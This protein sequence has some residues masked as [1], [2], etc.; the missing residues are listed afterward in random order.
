MNNSILNV[1]YNEGERLIPFV[2]HNEDEVIR[3]FSSYNFFA[4]IIHQDIQEKGINEVNILDIGFGCGYGCFILSKIQGVKQVTGIDVSYACKSYAQEKYG[5]RN[6]EFVIADAGEYLKQNHS[7]NYITSRGV[8][9]HIPNGLS[10]TNKSNYHQRLIIDVPYNEKPGN[11]HH[12]LLGIK[13]DAFQE[14]E[15]YELFYE[16]LDGTIYDAHNKPDDANMILCVASRQGLPP[17]SKMFDFPIKPVTIESVK[18]E[19]L[20]RSEDSISQ[21][22]NRYFIYQQ[23]SDLLLAV[24]KVIH[25]VDVV[26]DIGP[27]IAPMNYFRPKFHILL[28]PF[29]EY[30]QILTHRF[31]NDGSVFI[32]SDTAQDFMS[33]LATNSV[34]SVFLLDLIEHLPK[35]D[36]VNLLA[37]AE[38][39]ARKQIIIFTPLGFMPQT[40]HEDEKDAWGLGG[41]SV[42]EHLSGWIP[43]DFGS[44]WDFYICES[45]HK[46]DF[47]NQRLDKEYGTFF[48][49][50]NF[51]GKPTPTPESIPNIRPLLPSE[52]EF[53]KVSIELNQTK[54]AL[55]NTQNQLVDIQ[56]QLVNTQNQLQQLE[57]IV[58]HPIVRALRKV[59]KLLI[60][61]KK[62]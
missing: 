13:E 53:K 50:K 7:F 52:I 56:N 55:V 30:V 14:Y 22:H 62:M 51:F 48:A 17:V 24:Q 36:G 19:M 23:P 4:Q 37:H 58:Q 18:N 25:E 10:L 40:V 2:T 21:A 3:H 15:N 20:A 44:G 27:G 12:V 11:E 28:E 31:A 54:E 1:I 39:V 32:I 8:L 60:Y 29:T 34:D 33:S 57:K 6:V 45:Y 49:V 61:T 59:R 42:Q 35:E 43:E 41:G 26:L 5:A 9:E 46:Y 47:R 38:R 16:G